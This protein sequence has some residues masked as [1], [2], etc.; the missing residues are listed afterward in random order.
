MPI[1]LLAGRLRWPQVGTQV[2]ER[3][4]EGAVVLQR[5]LGANPTQSMAMEEGRVVSV[6]A[7]DLCHCPIGQLMSRPVFSKGLF[8]TRF[9]YNCTYSVKQAL[10]GVCCRQTLNVRTGIWT[11]GATPPT[12]LWQAIL[13]RVRELRAEDESLQAIAN[14]V[15]VKGRAIVGHWLSGIRKANGAPFAALMTYAERLGIDYRSYFPGGEL[16]VQ[17]T[18]SDCATCRKL[19]TKEKEIQKLQQQVDRMRLE[20]A[21]RDGMVEALERQLDIERKTGRQAETAPAE[22][23]MA[24]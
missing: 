11:S 21:K 6:K 16:H 19:L 23:K 8:M 7:R 2:A 15:G 4:A 24:G 17:E 9:V 10:T 5:R 1:R 20:L 3:D 22:R 12:R 14:S 18:V 13:N